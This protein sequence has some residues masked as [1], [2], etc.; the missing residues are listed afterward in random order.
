MERSNKPYWIAFNRI[1]RRTIENW[2]LMH[3]SALSSRN[4]FPAPLLFSSFSSWLVYLRTCRVPRRKM[5]LCPVV[6][7][8]TTRRIYFPPLLFLAYFA[9]WG[10]SADSRVNCEKHRLRPFMA[11]SAACDNAVWEFLIDSF[12]ARDLINIYRLRKN[13]NF[14]KMAFLQRHLCWWYLG[15]CR[16]YLANRLFRI[17]FKIYIQTYL[18]WNCETFMTNTFSDMK[19]SWEIFK[20]TSYIRV[21]I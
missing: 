9:P 1:A 20:W 17:I 11:L 4:I 7:T 3:R 14:Y 8:L 10:F 12:N 15:R 21:F 13:N 16:Y 2:I 19:C 18:Q 6:A 5:I